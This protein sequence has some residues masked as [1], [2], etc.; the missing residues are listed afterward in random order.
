VED[1]WGWWLYRKHLGTLKQHKAV[2]HSIGI[3]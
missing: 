1:V 2:I 3:Q